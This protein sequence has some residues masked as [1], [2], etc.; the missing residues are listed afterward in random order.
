MDER[1]W[2]LL[3]VAIFAAFLLFRMR[4]AWSAGKTPTAVRA[5]LRDAK[6]RISEAKTDAER[7]VALADAGDACAQSVARTN[8]AVG[9]YLRAMRTDP[10]SEQL[11]LR[12]SAALQ[13]RPQALESLLWRRLGAE[14]WSDAR[15]PAAIAAIQSLAALYAAGP[16]RHRIRARALEHALMAMGE[17]VAMR[18]PSLSEM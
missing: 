17:T 4:P 2:L 6:A 18:T 11:V 10:T 15:R 5:A 7:A 1:I 12:A 16:L 3:S 13:R 8:G 9:F 14:D